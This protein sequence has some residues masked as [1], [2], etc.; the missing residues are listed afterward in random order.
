MIFL[1]S[2]Y[3]GSWLR[4]AAEYLSLSIVQ[5]DRH[6]SVALSSVLILDRAAIGL[7]GSRLHLLAGKQRV[8]GGFHIV[9]RVFHVRLVGAALVVDGAGI[10]EHALLIDDE[11]MRRGLGAVKLAERAFRIEDIG[12]L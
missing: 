6:Q 10:G 12:S 3:H 1:A 4:K 2:G 5:A 7:R 9:L 11:H 8:D